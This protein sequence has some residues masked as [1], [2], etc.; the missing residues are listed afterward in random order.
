M[1]PLRL[2][3]PEGEVVRSSPTGRMIRCNAPRSAAARRSSCSKVSPLPCGPCRASLANSLFTWRRDWLQ[4]P[5]DHRCQRN[6]WRRADAQRPPCG[7]LPTPELARSTQHGHPTELA[8]HRRPLPTLP[9][10]AADSK[11]DRKRPDM[12]HHAPPRRTP[13]AATRATGFERR[14]HPANRQQL[15]IGLRW[16]S[17]RHAR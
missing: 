13:S 3:P 17:G 12:H 8:A 2:T 14:T 16:C 7:S 15:P 4:Q 6:P 1:S 9:L 10:T 5:E 11:H